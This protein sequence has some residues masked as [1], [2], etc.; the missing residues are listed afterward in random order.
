M[1]NFHIDIKV[2]ISSLLNVVLLFAN[3][4]IKFKRQWGSNPGDFG[5][6]QCRWPLINIDIYMYEM[7]YRIKLNLTV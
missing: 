3:F 6:W 7:I 1:W 5:D 2:L 4:E